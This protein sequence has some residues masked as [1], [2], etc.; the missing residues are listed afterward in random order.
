MQQRSRLGFQ[1]FSS[2]RARHFGRRFMGVGATVAALAIVLAGCFSPK[3]P[4]PP[5]PKFRLAAG[6][7][8]TLGTAPGASACHFARLDRAG[9]TIV[10]ITSTTGQRYVE[11]RDTDSEF[12]T[13]G[14]QTWVRADSPQDTHHFGVVGYPYDPRSSGF[15][16]ALGDGDYRMGNQNFFDQTTG[17]WAGSPGWTNDIP[18]GRY[19]LQNGTSCQF[20]VLRNFTG[21]D[22]SIWLSG[23]G[24][25]DGHFAA[26]SVDVPG[27]TLPG[28]P[29]TD[30]VGLRLFNCGSPDIFWYGNS[31]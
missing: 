3:P 26:G 20:E 21:E 25:G 29:P 19:Q 16:L 13:S 17:F 6:L 18:Y 9:K 22:N 15:K 14:C 4:P 1:G 10:D 27:P 2:A 8:H 30:V 28:E 11:T 31:G 5:P 23:D 24:S 7:W 12:V